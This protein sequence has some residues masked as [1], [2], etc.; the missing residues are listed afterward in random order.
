MKYRIRVEVE[1][2]K[3]NPQGYD[4]ETIYEQT[5]EDLNVKVLVQNI[6]DCSK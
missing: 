2:T 4:F 1:K 6:L 3:V 5:V